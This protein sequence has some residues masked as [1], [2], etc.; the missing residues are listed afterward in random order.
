MF[1]SVRLFRLFLAEQTDPDRFYTALAEDAVSQVADHCELAG[2]TVLDV[3]GGPGYC[4]AMA[5]P[6]TAR[7]SRTATGCRS[8]TAALTSVFPQTS[9]STYATR[10]G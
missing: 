3:G 5:G 4:T 10:A 7:W 8:A 1:R 2:S 6:R 9:S